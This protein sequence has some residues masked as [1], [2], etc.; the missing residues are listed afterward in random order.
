MSKIT[1][2]NGAPAGSEHPRCNWGA[3]T[4]ACP[5]AAHQ[6]EEN[7]EAENWEAENWEEENCEE[8]N[9]EEDE[10]AFVRWLVANLKGKDPAGGGGRG[11]IW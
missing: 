3:V 2:K 7:C 6:G 9:C 8:E 5:V 11:Y 1:A 10:A 4:E